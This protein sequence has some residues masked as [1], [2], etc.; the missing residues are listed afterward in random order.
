[1]FRLFLIFLICS[2][3]HCFSCR[4]ESIHTLYVYKAY[5]FLGLVRFLNATLFY[6]IIT[7]LPLAAE[8]GLHFSL[9]NLT[10]IKTHQFESWKWSLFCLFVFCLGVVEKF[11]VKGLYNLALPF[12]SCRRIKNLG[13]RIVSAWIYSIPFISQVT[14]ET[15]LIPLCLIKHRWQIIPTLENWCED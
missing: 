4:L 12:V 14:R 9:T 1:M 3:L 7:Q 5:R 13:S 15:Y 10:V 8:E 6:W 2:I 11:S